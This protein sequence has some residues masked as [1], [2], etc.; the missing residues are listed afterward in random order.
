MTATALP[1]K[2]YESSHLAE[3]AKCPLK[4]S[5]PGISGHFHLLVKALATLSWS[6]GV[7]AWKIV[8]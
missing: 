1:S 2:E 7:I 5:R 3:C 6:L 4:V 8:L